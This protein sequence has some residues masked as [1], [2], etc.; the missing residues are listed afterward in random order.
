MNV[1]PRRSPEPHP[2]QPAFVA[3]LADEICRFVA[4]G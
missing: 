2:D 3:E 4:A 1:T